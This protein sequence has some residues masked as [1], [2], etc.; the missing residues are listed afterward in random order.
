MRRTL[1]AH[2]RSMDSISQ[3]PYEAHRSKKGGVIVGL[4]H[5]ISSLGDGFKELK[6]TELNFSKVSGRRPP[7]KKVVMSQQKAALKA[8]DAHNTTHYSNV[9]L[10]TGSAYLSAV[11]TL[12]NSCEILDSARYGASQQQPTLKGDSAHER[13]HGTATSQSQTAFAAVAAIDDARRASLA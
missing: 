10:P 8:G 13:S 2:Q 3:R 12:P 4:N 11:G 7:Q 1:Q 9:H 5:D 6:P